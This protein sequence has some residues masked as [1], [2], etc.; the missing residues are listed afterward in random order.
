M[1]VG[2]LVLGLALSAC[3]THSLVLR[4]SEPLTG[5]AIDGARLIVL[6]FADE[7]DGVYEEG[8]WLDDAEEPAPSLSKLYAEALRQSGAFAAVEYRDRSSSEAAAVLA[9]LGPGSKTYVLAGRIERFKT[10]MVTHWWGWITPTTYLTALGFPFAPCY[11]SCD[12]KARYR[13]LAPD[14]RPVLGETPVEGQAGVDLFGATYWTEKFH[15]PN[16]LNGAANSS[17][18]ALTAGIVQSLRL[19]DHRRREPG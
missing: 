1:R 9:E 4:P 8:F 5:E 16:I 2:L 12:I 6:R 19:S 17:A 11:T 18:S 10:R 15:F 13:L 7:T 3:S 14:G